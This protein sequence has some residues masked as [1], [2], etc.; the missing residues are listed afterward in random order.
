[1]RMVGSEGTAR[2]DNSMKI[3]ME[4]CG[5]KYHYKWYAINNP[6]HTCCRK[7]STWCF[8]IFKEHEN[9]TKETELEVHMN[10]SDKPL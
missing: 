2:E 6:L 5:W 4:E 3:K 1:M 8:E 10:F 9:T 7:Q